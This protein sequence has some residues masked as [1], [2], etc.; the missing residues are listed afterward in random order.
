MLVRSMVDADGTI[1][2]IEVL[3]SDGDDFRKEVMG[4]L[5][6]MLKWV[7]AMQNGRKAPSWFTQRVSFIGI[8]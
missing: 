8:E 7:P 1:S 6:E 4:V 3:Q 5:L 2:K